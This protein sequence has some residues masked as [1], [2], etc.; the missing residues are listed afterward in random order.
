LANRRGIERTARTARE[1]ADAPAPSRP[2]RTRHWAEQLIELSASWFTE[3]GLPNDAT[4][5]EA[6]RYKEEGSGETSSVGPEQWVAVD[7][8]RQANDELTRVGW[9]P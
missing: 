9:K 6:I 8:A 2:T 3:D 7:F 1:R 4:L 5:R